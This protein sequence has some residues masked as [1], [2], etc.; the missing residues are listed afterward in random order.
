[1]DDQ[2]EELKGEK[3]ATLEEINTNKEELEK[4]K[5]LL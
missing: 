5:L 2:C 3:Q 4:L 1:M